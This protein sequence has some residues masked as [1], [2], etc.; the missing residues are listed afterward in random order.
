MDSLCA[1]GRSSKANN[2]ESTGE[3]GIGFKSIF[4]VADQV[5]IHSYPYSFTFDTTSKLGELG[6][7]VPSW[8]DPPI[9]TTDGTLLTFRLRKRERTRSVLSDQLK[10]F[11][12]YS[13]LFS[14]V[15]RK[16]KIDNQFQGSSATTEATLRGDAAAETELVIKEGDRIRTIESFVMRNYSAE[17]AI[18]VAT[19]KCPTSIRLAFPVVGKNNVGL[20]RTCQQ[21][22]R[23]YAFQ[24]IQD[25]GFSVSEQFRLTQLTPCKADSEVHDPRRVHLGCQPKPC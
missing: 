13:L 12:F 19:R 3:N 15:L 7:L 11:D 5:T 1:I 24:A 18:T 17:T 23:T 10:S 6:M 22:Y 14:R 25:F 21:S 20:P 2:L 4:K 9:N 8:V 16:I